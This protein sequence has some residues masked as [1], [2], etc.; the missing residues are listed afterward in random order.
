MFL[1]FV[2]FASLV[3][4]LFIKDPVFLKLIGFVIAFTALS[5]IIDFCFG[6]GKH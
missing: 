4:L 3:A 6:G 5:A 2:F 1:G